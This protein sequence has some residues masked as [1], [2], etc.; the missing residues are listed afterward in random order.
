MNPR[1][2]LSAI[3]NDRPGIVSELSGAISHVGG[4]IADSRMS[5]LGGEFALMLLVEGSETVIGQIEQQLETLQRDLGLKIISKRTGSAGG[6]QGSA[7]YHVE[8]VAMDHPGIVSNIAGFL[9]DRGINIQELDTRSY[10]AAHTGTPMFA[11][12][13]TGQH[14]R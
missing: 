9:S 1:L 14:P 10:S 8:V 6:V 3:G 5:V 4:N 12:S 11:L 2:V 13:M 7:A